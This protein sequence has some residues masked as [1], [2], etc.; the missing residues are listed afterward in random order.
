MP[1]RAWTEDELMALP[2]DG[3]KRELVGGE[4]L[5]MNPA[6]R[7][8]GMV[9]LRLGA[10][11][12]AHVDAHGLGWAFDSSTGFWMPSGNLRVPDLSFIARSK[13]PEAPGDGFGRVPPDLAVEVLSPSDRPQDVDAKVREYLGAGV[14]MVWVIDPQ[15]RR[16]EVHR[17]GA[18][19]EIVDDRGRLSGADVIPG[20]S[21][22]LAEVLS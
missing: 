5:V 6:G 11:L 14:A 16:A 2:Q 12:L 20:F 8:H 22:P 13:H 4:I 21:C 3:R 10:A 19:V 9:S 18:E 15:A 1:T 17:P 7:R